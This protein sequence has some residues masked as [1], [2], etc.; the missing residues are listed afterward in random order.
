MEEFLNFYGEVIKTV[1]SL[2]KEQQSY[3]FFSQLKFP[4]QITQFVV[5]MNK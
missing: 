1:K 5:R 3:L 4:T 2:A